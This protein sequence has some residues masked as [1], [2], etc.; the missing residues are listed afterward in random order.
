MV[1]EKGFFRT[2]FVRSTS[3]LPWVFLGFLLKSFSLLEIKPILQGRR[4][5]VLSQIAAQ[6]AALRE[7]FDALQVLNYR[8]S[9]DECVAIVKEV[10]A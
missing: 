3:G 6:D 1:N 8:R 9:F 2:R 5:D 10:L 7:T 4:D